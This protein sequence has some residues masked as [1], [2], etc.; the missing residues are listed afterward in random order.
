VRLAKVS[1]FTLGD[2][3]KRLNGTASSKGARHGQGEVTLTLQNGAQQRSPGQRDAHLVQTALEHAQRLSCVAHQEQRV[4]QTALVRRFGRTTRGVDEG[5]GAG[6]DTNRQN[7][8]ARARQLDYR[9]TVASAQIQ[10]RPR[11]AA[12]QL[13]ELADVDLAQMVASDHAHW[14]SIIAHRPLG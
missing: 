3:H 6:V 11:V 5:R 14:A 4:Q 13:V 7:L 8:R 10:D 1:R 9:G 2:G 12:D